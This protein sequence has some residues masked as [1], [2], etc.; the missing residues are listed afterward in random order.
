MRFSALLVTAAVVVSANAATVQKREVSELVQVCNAKLREATTELTA[1][2]DG[3]SEFTSSSGYFAALGVQSKEQSLDSVL[4]QTSELCCRSL[5]ISMSD[6]ETD[7][8][9][10]II[11]PLIDE[12]V[13]ALKMIEDKKPDFDNTPLT[14]ILVKN[15]IKSMERHTKSL[16][17]CFSQE[18]AEDRYTTIRELSHKLGDA[19][20][21]ARFTYGI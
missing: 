21:R 6:E 16:L 2:R 20:S 19:F 10:D 9:I 3:V 17:D 12:A 8:S 7:A 13:G 11:S 15:D 18:S 14:T 5:S 1:L 4:R